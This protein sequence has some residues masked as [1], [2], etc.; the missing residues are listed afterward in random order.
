MMLSEMGSEIQ[1]GRPMY[2]VLVSPMVTNAPSIMKSPWAK[3]T[4]S[5]AL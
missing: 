4:A 5:V 2:S 1:N 3:F